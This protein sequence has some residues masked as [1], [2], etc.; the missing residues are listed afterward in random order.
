[1]ESLPENRINILSDWDEIVTHMEN[2]KFS[3]VVCFEV[4]EHFSEQ[5]QIKALDRMHEVLAAD[6]KLVVSVPIESGLPSV[7]KNLIRRKT[8][9]DNEYY[10]FNN[11]IHSL[12]KTPIPECRDGDGYLF[13]MGFY[14]EELEKL[15]AVR[16]NI[17]LRRFSPFRHLGKNFN[18]QVFYILHPK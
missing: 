15:M 18:S 7:V 10:S 13:H 16:F 9:K 1:M 6:G 12:L 3:H 11:I 8:G 4:L 17:A 14:F 2:K 5:R